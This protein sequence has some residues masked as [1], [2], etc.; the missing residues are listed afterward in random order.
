[1]TRCL[2]CFR[3]MK[4]ASLSWVSRDLLAL[5]Y[6]HMIIHMESHNDSDHVS[7][8]AVADEQKEDFHFL[9]SWSIVEGPV[10]TQSRVAEGLAQFMDSREWDTD[11]VSAKVSRALPTSQPLLSTLV[12]IL[13]QFSS[14]MIRGLP[15]LLCARTKH[16]AHKP[17]TVYIQSKTVTFSVWCF[18]ISI[19]FFSLK[20]YP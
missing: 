12:S 15:E 10:L 6:P 16:L 14:E 20:N 17:L 19:I 9:V 18:S 8:V 1:M 3:P 13:P 11:K 4:M 5:D 2:S 7:S